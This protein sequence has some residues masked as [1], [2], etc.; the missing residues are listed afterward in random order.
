MIRIGIIGHRFLQ[1]P[2]Q[3][4]VAEQ[5]RRILMQ[6][7]EQEPRGVVACSAIAEGADSI[8]AQAALKLQLPLEIVLPFIEYE[9]D[10]AAGKARQN[11]LLLKAA[12][13]KTTWLPFASRSEDAYAAGMHWMLENSD[14]V[15]AVWN[16]EANKGRGGT[17]D[18]VKNIISR[19]LDWIHIDICNY[20]NMAH[21]HK[22]A[23]RLQETAGEG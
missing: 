14:I 2:Q 18:G 8:F 12:A 19:G 13:T 6:L 20:S 4:F 3:D 5:C 16:G 23:Y 17:S 10:F 7:Q 11:Y 15:I 22:H 1:L 9:L 21:L